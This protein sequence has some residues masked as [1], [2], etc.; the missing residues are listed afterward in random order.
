M[1]KDKFLWVFKKIPR[2]FWKKQTCLE[3]HLLTELFVYFSSMSSCSL[4]LCLPSYLLPLRI[5]PKLVCIYHLYSAYYTPSPSSPANV[6]N[7]VLTQHQH[8]PSATQQNSS[9]CQTIR[10]EHSCSPPTYPSRFSATLKL[11]P[12]YFSQQNDLQKA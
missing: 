9:D 3:S 11:G 2:I 1:K 5:P 8:K 12:S 6:I 4:R 7:L 10:H